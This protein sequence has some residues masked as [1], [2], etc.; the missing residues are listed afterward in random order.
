MELGADMIEFDLHRSSDGHLIVV[1]DRR[2]TRVGKKRWVVD[3]MTLEE[4]KTIDVGFWFGE[5]YKGERIPTL[6]EVLKLTRDR[7]GLNVEIKRGDRLY[8]LIEK[9]LLDLIKEYGMLGDTLISSFDQIYLENVREIEKSA[10]IGL[11]MDRGGFKEGL[12]KAISIGAET[13][14]LP[15]KM[16]TKKVIDMAKTEGLKLYVY[17]VNEVPGMQRYIDMGVDGIFTNYP[18]RLGRLFSV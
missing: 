5:A 9:P 3:K 12:K 7:I 10:R 1:H 6:R 11:L 18:D 13:I 16:L 2:L 14:N 17:T 4:L 15:T 8:D